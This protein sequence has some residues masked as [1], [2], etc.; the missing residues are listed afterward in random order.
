MPKPAMS[1]S[2]FVR[3]ANIAH[4]DKYDYSKT[5]Y[6]NMYNNID[7][8][9]PIHG[10]FKVQAN[11]HVKNWN[12]PTSKHK[13]CGCGTCGRE[14]TRQ[15]NLSGRLSQQDILSKFTAVHGIKYNY[16]RVQYI[17]Y[18]TPVNIGCSIHGEFLQRPDNHINGT[19]CPRCKNSHGQNRVEQALLQH[20]IQYFTEYSF[21]DCK[22]PKTNHILKFDFFIPSLNTLIE[23]DGEQH[24]K[25]TKFHQKMS[26]DKQ[27]QLLSKT[28]YRDAIKTEY[29]INNHIN[30]VRISY[31]E[32]DKIELII[33]HLATAPP[34][35][36]ICI[37]NP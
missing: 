14:F 21:P 36:Y 18:E 8:I 25:P 24:F 11:N 6:T 2:E 35:T 15:R 30:L 31:L 3:R 1:Q 17:N 33:E 19:G 27:Q 9:C 12:N 28:Q 5:T 16:S 32:K 26:L 7:V 29:A 4:S 34:T 20:N 13:P 23:Y 10:L 37:K 22:N